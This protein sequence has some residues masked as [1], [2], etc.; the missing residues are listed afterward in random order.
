M[1]K[2]WNVV[3][4]VL[5]WLVTVAMAGVAVLVCFASAS[6]GAEVHAVIKKID[7][8][9]R[10]LV[11]TA[12]QQERAICVPEGVKVVNAE[13]R[14]SPDGLK[15]KDLCEGAAVTLV[16]ERKDGRPLLRE[17]RLGTNSAGG[18]APWLSWAA[19]LWTNGTTPRSDGVFFTIDDFQE[20]DHMHES[21]GGQEK[22]GTLLLHFFKSDP[23]TKSWF[24]R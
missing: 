9:Q 11:V 21:P 5:F 10:L 17:I 1:T 15:T 3:A 6:V 14:E 18:P 16:A 24:V 2:T 4:P 7:V 23:T 19:Y 20:K 12:G 8:G 22:V 13:G